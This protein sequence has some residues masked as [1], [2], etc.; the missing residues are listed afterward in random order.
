VSSTIDRQSPTPYYEQLVAVLE[1]RIASGELAVGQ[2]LPSENELCTEFGLSRATVRQALQVLESRGGAQR[3][4]G[5]GVFVSESSEPENG[6]IIQGREGFL[7]N[8]IRNGNRAVTTRV[9]RH[10]RVE[11]PA[12]AARLLDVPDGASG[13][14][15]VR[16]RTIDG[17]PA[18]YSIN[19]SPERLVPVITEAADVLDGTGSLTE[20][21]E[22]AGYALGGAQRTIRADAAGG[23]IADALEV[24]TGSPLLRIR[25]TSWTPEGVRFDI[26]ETWV[27]SE[28]IPLEI[29]VGVV[30][31]PRT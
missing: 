19:R 27:R 17:T 18:L 10:G 8:A 29:N 25:S 28:V 20:A 1:E 24:P 15:L 7:E 2:R 22:R 13:Y 16:V 23:E 3:V 9:L 14:E 30:S 31:L 26:Y 6:W 12:F 4:P 21:V 5:R 11:L